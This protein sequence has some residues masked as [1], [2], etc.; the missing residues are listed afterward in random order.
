MTGVFAR[1]G[2]PELFAAIIVVALNVYVL[3]GGADFGGGVWDLLAS[4]PRRDRQRDLVAHAIGPIWE[5]NHVWLVLVVVL[6]FTAFPAAFAALGTVLHI[7]LALMLVGIV[8][9][10]SAFVFRSY[11]SRTWEQRRNWGRVF[12]VASTLTPLLLGVVIGAVSTGAVGSA[13]TRIGAAGFRSVYVAPWWAPFPIA[14]GVLALALFA[15]LAAVYLAYETRDDAL[16]EDFRRRAL[17]AAAAVFAAAFGALAM[18]HLEAPIVRAGL[19]NSAWALPFQVATGAAALAAIGALWRRRY[20]WAR[21]AAAAQVSL[22]LWGWAFAQFPYV[23]PPNL[24]IENTAAPRITLELVAWALAAGAALLIPSLVYLR[25]T[26][27]AR[28]TR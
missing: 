17:A 23:V 7:P 11:G 25:R 8:M 1:I 26:F 6:T 3:T 21:L 10:G 27:A 19:E 14:V 20:A 2:L 24:T 5:A 4:G 16:R 9:R 15:M 28:R 13:Q 22:I 18:A 12:A